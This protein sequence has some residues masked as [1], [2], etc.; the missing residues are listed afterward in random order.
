MEFLI[1]LL[2]DLAVQD[3]AFSPTDFFIF[4]TNT[5]FSIGGSDKCVN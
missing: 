1:H 3:I 2:S 4:A 5:V